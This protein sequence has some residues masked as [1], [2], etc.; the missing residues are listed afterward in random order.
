MISFNIV[1]TVL[2][3]IGALTGWIVEPVN[4][5]KAQLIWIISAGLLFLP[6]VMLAS[7]GILIGQ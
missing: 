6:L 2:G 7:Y 5:E 4:T 1:L 3:L